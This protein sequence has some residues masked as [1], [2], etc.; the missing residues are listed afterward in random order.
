M[1]VGDFTPAVVRIAFYSR[2]CSRC[3]RCRR[4]L[5]WEERG[6]GWSAHHRKPRGAGGTR[7]AAIGGVANCLIL[8]GSGTTGCHGWVEGHRAEAIEDGLLI[9]RLGVGSGFDPANV[10]ARRVDG[11]WWSLT[12]TGRSVEVELE[13]GRR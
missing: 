5:R 1:G 3:F 7:D 11:S 2:E 13:G 4:D 10:R 9:S 12:S 6:I 8:C